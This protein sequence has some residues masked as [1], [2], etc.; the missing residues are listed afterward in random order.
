MA[1]G[2]PEVPLTK[3]M[4]FSSCLLPVPVLGAGGIGSFLL[5]LNY[6]LKMGLQ[7]PNL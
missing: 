5:S 2:S 1:E 4:T 6:T 7:D 3:K